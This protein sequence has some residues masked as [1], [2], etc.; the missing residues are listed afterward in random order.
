[1]LPLRNFMWFKRD[2]NR[3][4]NRRLHRH[5]VLDVKLRSD[6]V[7]ATRIRLGLFLFLAVAGP[8]FGIYLLWRVGE[9]ILNAFVYEN[10]DFAVQQVE[11]QTDGVIAPEQLRRW[12][13][14]KPG[15]NLIA[16]DLAAVKRNLELISAVDTVSVERVLPRTLKIRVTERDPIAQVNVP[17]ADGASGIAVSVFQ[18]DAEGMVMQPLDPRLCTVSL[19][20]LNSQLPVISGMNAFQLQPGR[21]VELPQVQAALKLVSAFASSPM[22]GLADL[23]RVDVSAPGVIMATTGQGSQITFGLENF[24][25]QLRRWRDIYDYGKQANKGD[26][27]SVDLAVANNVPVRWM[28]ASSAPVITTPKTVKPSK[29]RRKN[30]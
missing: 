9:V 22:A 11:V 4:R 10:K 21:R 27:A 25:Q 5:N 29:I 3:N 30:V 8:F 1:L 26:I 6:Q 19:N 20:Q 23:R 12:A 13:G 15:A 2:Q 14:V 24:E 16:L 7:R 18:L 17:R 28:L